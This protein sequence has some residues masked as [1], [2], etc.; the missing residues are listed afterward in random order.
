[1]SRRDASR[2][3]DMIRL[4]EGGKTLEDIGNIYHISRERVRQIIGN[5]GVYFISNIARRIHVDS[6][7][8]VKDLD[9]LLYGRGRKILRDKLKKIH[10]AISGGAGKDGQ[11]IE[12]LVSEKLKSIGLENELMPLRHPFDIQLKNGIRIDVKATWTKSITSPFQKN[13][14][15]RFGV[16]KKRKA[17][18][19]DFYICYIAPHNVFFVIPEKEV[20]LSNFLYISYPE[21]KRSWSKW[22]DYEN[23]FDLL[24][25]DATKRT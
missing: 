10:H 5:T 20:N 24:R 9:G 12:W 23:R 2:I 7:M 21:P 11:E 25:I 8:T 17:G 22:Q 15:Y 4:R 18:A 16:K 3:Q 6:S 1:M 14:M 13:E 19:C